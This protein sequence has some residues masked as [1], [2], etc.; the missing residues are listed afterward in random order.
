MLRLEARAAATANSEAASVVS[1]RD[2][3]QGGDRARLPGARIPSER[4]GGGEVA[5]GVLLLD[6]AQPEQA[7][8]RERSCHHAPPGV[9]AVERAGR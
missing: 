7:G 3:V 6:L 5:G 9:E 4:V 8:E 2:V 1:R